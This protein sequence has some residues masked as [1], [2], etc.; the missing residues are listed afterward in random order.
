MLENF[1]VQEVAKLMEK[2]KIPK[3]VINIIQ[4]T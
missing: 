1:L 4:G 3:S 2:N